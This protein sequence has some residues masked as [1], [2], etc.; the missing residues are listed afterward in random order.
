MANKPIKNSKL[1]INLENEEKTPKEGF[2]VTLQKP[3]KIA[4]FGKKR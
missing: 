2:K 3:S 1:E 4:V